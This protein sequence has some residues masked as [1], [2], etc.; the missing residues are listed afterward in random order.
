[1]K[2]K[3]GK[4]SLPTKHT[5]KTKHFKGKVLSLASTD[6]QDATKT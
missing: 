2:Q 5:G 3:E 4:D 1:M 6:M